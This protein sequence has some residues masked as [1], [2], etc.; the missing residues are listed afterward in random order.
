MKYRKVQYGESVDRAKKK[1]GNKLLGWGPNTNDMK[2]KK[3]CN[4]LAFAKELKNNFSKLK[5]TLTESRGQDVFTS[6]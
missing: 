5:L 2:K 4:Q 6:S 1:Q 3:K